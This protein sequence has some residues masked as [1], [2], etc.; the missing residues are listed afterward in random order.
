MYDFA[1]I[2]PCFNEE[3]QLDHT[4]V[5]LINFFQKSKWRD[6]QIVIVFVNDGSQDKTHQKITNFPEQADYNLRCMALSY[7]KNKGKGFAIRHAVRT[8]RAQH[9]AF[10]DADLVFPLEALEQMF[11]ILKGECNLV[12]GQRKAANHPSLYARFRSFISR[13]L[14]KF[15]AS[16]VGLGFVDTQCGIKAFDKKIAEQIFPNLQ[17]DK[18]AFDVELIK[19]CRDKDLQIISHPVTF[20]YNPKSSVR[21]SDGFRFIIDV[22]RIARK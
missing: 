8:V 3:E 13:I 6:K 4:Y 21:T 15:V 5:Q 11:E 22:L 20:K 16:V 17:E 14:Q 10:I 12:I 9:Y 19:K 18:F 2:I 1:I 7:K